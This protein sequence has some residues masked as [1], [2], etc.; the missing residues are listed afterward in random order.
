MHSHHSR[1]KLLSEKGID[2]EGVGAVELHDNAVLDK[3]IKEK[4][5][6]KMLQNEKI[7][8]N[9]YPRSQEW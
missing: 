1:A 8:Q 2:G 5:K 4:T 7:N 3:F 9:Y 6:T